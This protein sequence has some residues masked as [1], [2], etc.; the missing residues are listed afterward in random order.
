MLET[1]LA[2]QRLTGTTFRRAREVVSWLGAVQAQDYSGATWGVALRA[3]D[4]TAAAIERE[5]AAGRILRTH[6][7][8][9]TWHFVAQADIRW[10][11]ALTGP[12]VRAASAYY[13]A[14]LAIDA[15]ADDAGPHHRRGGARGRPLPDPQR[16]GRPAEAGWPHRGRG[17]AAG[18]HRHGARARRGDLQRAAPG[19]AAHLRAGRG[20]RPAG[21]RAA[22]R[23]GSGRA[24]PPL[25]PESRP[26]HRPRLRLVV[27]AHGEGRARGRRRRRRRVGAAG[28]AGPRPGRRRQLPAAQL[29]RVP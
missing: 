21:P 1:R 16:A 2:N 6:V 18:L 10:L 15:P 5:F 25:L 12:R 3:R 9:E 11:Q 13:A 26:G 24:G 29:R 27:G 22:A 7:M 23:R 19:Q 17:P 20:A 14:R 8:R 4:L 28:A